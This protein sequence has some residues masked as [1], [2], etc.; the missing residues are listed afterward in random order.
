M[1]ISIDQLEKVR[2]RHK[3]QKI[4]FCSGM[5]D[6]VHPGHILFFED[7]KKIG[8]VL[9][10]GVGGDKNIKERKNALRPI[11]NQAMRLKM[12]DSLRVVDYCLGFSHTPVNHRLEIIEMVLKKLHPDVYAINNDAFDIPYREK[13]SKE[14]SVE[15]VVLDRWCPPEFEGV[16]TTKLIEKIQKGK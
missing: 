1:I 6:L 10:V 11:M 8:D 13:I 5:F 7:C 3:D 16:S 9:V 14:N 2:A 4:V 15:L 12:V